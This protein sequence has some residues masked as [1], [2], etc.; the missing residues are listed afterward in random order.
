MLG[1]TF[2]GYLGGGYSE[3]ISVTS[4]HDLQPEHWN[5][6][7]FAENTINGAGL[8]YDI[9]DASRFMA[10]AT[11]GASMQEIELAVELGFEEWIETQATIDPSSVLNELLLIH[12]EVIDWFLA[13]GG[14]PTEVSEEFAY[15]NEFNYA[16]WNLNMYTDDQL[17]QRIALAL[18]EIFVISIESD[19]SNFGFGLASY[20]DI[21]LKHAF[22]NYRD[23]LLEITLHPCMGFYLSHLNN[24]REIPEDNIHPDEN[25]AREIMQLFSIGLYELNT[26]GTRKTDGEGNWIPT[27]G[28]QEIKEFAKVFTGLGVSEIVNNE[29]VEEPY[30]GLGIWAA[31]MTKPMKMYE[32]WHE[33]GEKHLLNGFNIPAGQTGLEDIE[34][35]IDNLFNHPN[36]GPF[37]GKLLI[38]RLVKSNPTPAYVERV[39]QAFNDNGQ[40]VRGN[41]EAVIKAILLDHEARECAWLNDIEAAR[42]REPFLRY[43]HFAKAIEK[44]QYY[45]RYWNACY[46]FHES[47]GQSPLW[48]PTVFNFFLPDFQPNGPIDDADLDAPEFQIHNARTSVSFWNEVNSW[49]IW[50]SLMYSWE[51]NDPAVVLNL[52]SLKELA[53]DPE[54]LVNRLDVLLTHGQLTDRTRKIIKDGIGQLVYNDYREERVRL[55]LYLIMISPDYAILR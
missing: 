44:E 50:N 14:D 55:A 5:R 42:M 26:D 21:L 52:E 7:A 47:T 10:Q 35:A 33:S 13:N 29:W 45:G 11:L 9:I 3:G 19:L 17:R 37:I 27:Y 4:S 16:W 31:D 38:Q 46:Q 20:Y 24:P 25:Y 6:T 41:M 39:A 28:Q 22:G 36:V 1:Q 15:W 51:E 49:A 48:A 30:F 8:N 2:E 53:R 40:G 12:Q 32:D 23:M 18:S 34:D 43:T 54:V